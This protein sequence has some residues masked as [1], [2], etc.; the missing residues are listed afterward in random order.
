MTLF[1]PA[2]KPPFESSSSFLITVETTSE[3]TFEGFDQPRTGPYWLTFRKKD[4]DGSEEM[5]RASPL[6][7][8]MRLSRIRRSFLLAGA[9]FQAP[10]F[11][12]KISIFF[13]SSTRLFGIELRICGG[14]RLKQENE[15]KM[16]RSLFRHI[17]RRMPLPF[18]EALFLDWAR[19]EDLLLNPA[20][21]A[22]HL[23]RME[24]FRG[25]FFS[26]VGIRR[27]LASLWFRIFGVRISPG[28]LE[29]LCRIVRR[30]GFDQGIEEMFE[31]NVAELWGRYGYPGS[32]EAPL[33]EI[34]P[35]AGNGK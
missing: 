20:E 12:P 9:S 14:F 26:S 25:K 27:G 24:E 3:E 28:R 6:G 33:I 32:S 1:F 5:E 16:L 34:L 30:E 17:L 22:L 13:P 8:T 31:Q 23:V 15:R 21:I 18:E 7:G 10:E 11:V 19:G 29:H 35:E 2:L 4:A